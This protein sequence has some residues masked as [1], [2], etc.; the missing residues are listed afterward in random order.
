[1]PRAAPLLL[2]IA[3]LLSGCERGARTARPAA[4][5][6]APPE[7]RSMHPPDP[8]IDG[9]LAAGLQAAVEALDQRIGADLGMAADQRAFGVLDLGHRE[10][11]GGSAAAPRLAMLRPDALFYGASVPKIAIVWANLMADRKPGGTPPEPAQDYELGRVI[12]QSDN[13][14]AAKYSRRVGL[15]FIQG[16]LDA[17]GFYDR[18]GRGGLWCG[19]H[20]GIDQPRHGDPIADHS[21]AATVRACLRYYWLLEQ[22][23]LG[24]A[25]VSAHLMRIFETPA[26]DLHNENF[27]R[28]L[29]GRE[30]TL[31][32]KSGLWE[33]W[34]L[35]TARVQHGDRVYVLAGMT[36]HPKGQDYLARMAAAVDDLLCRADARPPAYWHDLHAFGQPV[37]LACPRLPSGGAS[38]PAAAAAV[39]TFA[40]ILAPSFFNEAVLSWNATVPAGCGM[41]VELRVGRTWDD[42]WSPWLYVGDWGDVSWVGP[43]TTTFEHGR[44]DVDYFR[45][46]VRFDRA[47]VRIRAAGAGEAP[48]E[49]HV[50]RVTVCLSD[51]SGVPLAV[52]RQPGRSS[53][54]DPTLVPTNPQ[55]W[56]RR[57]AVP[58]RSQK[59]EAAELAGRICSPTSVAMV[60]A[61]RGVERSTGDVAAACFDAVHNLYGNWPRN[62]QAAY[63]FGVPGYVTRFSYWPEVERCI[64]AGQPL[65]AS[66]RV[67]RDGDLSGAPY[68]T[69]D[70]HLLVICGFDGRG[71]VLVNDPAARAP[72]AGVTTYRRADLERC[73]LRGS[74]GLAYVLE[75]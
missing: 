4:R 44:I 22:G 11:G 59:V 18:A 20:Y 63:T 10:A 8:V 66:I 6:A 28:G 2:A 16:L 53:L 31:I 68:R 58:F 62:V 54:L 39:H 43:R 29:S 61:Y 14:L 17:H 42:S 70:G 23:R 36:Q 24:D 72:D 12:K 37:V 51:T 71:D 50:A 21:H 46:D 25:E 3:V 56:Q 55:L 67:D 74:G 13:D 47:Q 40:P 38:Q 26:I 73:W 57:L 33:D 1:M 34:H 64:A 52:R 60:L 49:V 35:D 48:A 69:T 30:L 7:G 65:I 75:R 32:R 27:V 15:D 5:G 19:K 9:P 41:C 45:A